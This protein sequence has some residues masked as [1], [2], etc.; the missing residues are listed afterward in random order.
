MPLAAFPT[1]I[2]LIVGAVL[3]AATGCGFPHYEFPPPTNDKGDASPDASAPSSDA[4]P[5]VTPD[6]APEARACSSAADCSSA[7]GRT[8]C[9]VDAGRC[10]QCIA[11]VND[12]PWGLICDANGKC[13]SG[14]LS[15]QDCAPPDG[16]AS[17]P[18]TG[19]PDAGA[20]HPLMC[21]MPNKCW[22]CAADS[23]CPPSSTCE[24]QSQLCLPGCTA[25][26]ACAVGYL[27]CAGKCIDPATDQC[28]GCPAG[29]GECNGKPGDGC[30][31]PLNTAND[32]GDCGTKCQPANQR[33]TCETGSCVPGDCIEPFADCDGWP[34]T[35]CEVDKTKDPANCGGCHRACQNPHGGAPSCDN[36]VCSAKCDPGWSICDPI[37]GCSVDLQNDPKNC[38]TCGLECKGGACTAGRC[39]C[40]DMQPPNNLACS[41]ALTCG[42]YSV[43]GDRACLCFCINRLITCRINMQDGEGC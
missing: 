30:E 25:F 38:G 31:T 32:C 3:F 20:P 19:D 1:R 22:G 36:G 17:G 4:S 27:C 9:D 18:A 12:C 33:A 14:C 42:P 5:D 37:A 29:F 24:P 13:S 28:Q 10:V 15:T 26:H 35:G 43:S 8:L 21:A 11:G 23:D 41:G 2:A 7:T 6:V 40:P 16:G 34:S 39:D